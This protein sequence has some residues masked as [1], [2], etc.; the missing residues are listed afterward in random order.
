LAE[1]GEHQRIVDWTRQ[2]WGLML[3]CGATSCWEVFPG[4]DPRWYTRS[5][6]HA[7][8]AG[9]GYFL[10]TYQLGVRPDAPGFTR[11]RI[12]PIPADLSWARGRVP[13]SAG[14]IEVDWRRREG[15][16]RIDVSLPPGTEAT[17]VLPFGGEPRVRPTGF[18]AVHVSGKWHIELPAGGS[19]TAEQPDG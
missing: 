8:S 13:T 14:E 1:L 19:C 12:A 9:P 16:F 18:G 10:P 11:A 17:L 15:S 5:H 4:F 2:W 6:C 3:D 7:W